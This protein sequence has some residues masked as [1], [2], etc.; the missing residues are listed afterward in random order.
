[1]ESTT[2]STAPS[3]LLGTVLITG[4]CGFLGFHL[5]A[6]FLEDP[7]CS[8]VHV[9]DRNITHNLHDKAHYAQ[10]DITD[11][12]RVSSLLAQTKPS[13]IIHA[14]S[15]NVSFPVHGRNDYHNTNVAGTR[16]L[17]KLAEESESVKALVYTSTVDIYASP[18]HHNIA[19]SHPVWP[20]HPSLLRGEWGISEYDRTKAIGERL[21]R[22]A[23]CGRLKTA[24]VI[25]SHMY[26]VR[27]S[28]GL[29]T[30][31][32]MFDSDRG[33]PLFQVGR[34]ENMCEVVSADNVA[35]A[36]V[37][38]AK[39]LLD[40]S[41]A[42][43]KVDGEGFNVSDGHPVLFWHHVRQMWIAARGYESEE[44]LKGQVTVV[45]AWVMVLVVTLVE[46]SLL[47]FTLGYVEPPT[48][49]SRTALS[50]TVENHTY[51]IQK[52]RD[53]LGFEPVSNHDE[54]MAEAARW[55]LEN[56]KKTSLESKKQK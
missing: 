45:P 55:E 22:A 51:S 14:A 29:K 34:G 6:H 11:A 21:V 31:M 5:V 53:R 56:R 25:P 7:E 28:Q 30:I 17:L 40:P 24:T 48:K 2:R 26:G 35:T 15:P 38:A 39:A 44:E 20:E 37:L 1:M 54:V 27:D 32:D 3:P 42:R 9:L 52:A 47:V 36:H 4:G 12:D 50:Y 18:P 43:G 33:A 19:E 13:V 49:M 16:L 8:A 23:N 41:R 46:W 10:G